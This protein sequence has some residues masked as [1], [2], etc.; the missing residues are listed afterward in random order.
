MDNAATYFWNFHCKKMVIGYIINQFGVSVRCQ[1]SREACILECSL[2]AALRRCGCTP[3]NYPHSGD[4]GDKEDKEG[5]EEASEEAMG[6]ICDVFGNFCFAEAMKEATTRPPC[7]CPNDCRSYAYSI[8]VSASYLNEKIHCPKEKG[9]LKEFQGPLGLPKMFFSFYHLIV[10]K[11]SLLIF[12][13]NNKSKETFRQVDFDRQQ[14]CRDNL[15]FQAIVN[16]QLS[17]Q[18]VNNIT[19][20]RRLTTSDQISNLGRYIQISGYNI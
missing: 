19:R 14:Q 4:A 16:I 3:W 10:N 9:F 20:D 7:D 17:S 2:R 8:T 5:K 13:L 1:Y 6:R 12:Q 11:E 15:Q 18:L